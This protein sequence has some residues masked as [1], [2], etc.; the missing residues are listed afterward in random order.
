[1]FVWW[2]R[3]VGG[4]TSPGVAG[5]VWSSSPPAGPPDTSAVAG[6]LGYAVLIVGSPSL[7][8]W[9]ESVR[10]GRASGPRLLADALQV[11]FVV[12]GTVPVHGGTVALLYEWSSTPTPAGAPDTPLAAPARARAPTDR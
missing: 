5:D 3:T 2:G 12:A 9:I 8:L 1:M 6:R 7:G 11:L 4:F 10:F